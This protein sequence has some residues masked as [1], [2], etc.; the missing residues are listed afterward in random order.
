MVTG[1]AGPQRTGPAA[2]EEDSDRGWLWRRRPGSRGKIGRGA[3]PRMKGR[4]GAA[5]VQPAGENAGGGR[6][7]REDGGEVALRPGVR[8]RAEAPAGRRKEFGPAETEEARGAGRE[9]PKPRVGPRGDEAHAAG[10]EGG[11]ESA[12]VPGPGVR[13]CAPARGWAF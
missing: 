1:D 12:N 4:G 6:R 7:G 2:A 3:R 5:R 10:C 11:C 9:V 13:E 8:A